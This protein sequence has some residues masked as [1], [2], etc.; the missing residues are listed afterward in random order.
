M[1]IE[2]RLQRDFTPFIDPATDLR[3]GTGTHGARLQFIRNGVEHDYFYEFATRSATARHAKGRK[4]SNIRS[5]LASPEFADIRGLAA[6][7]ARTHRNTDLGALIP[8]E[9][10]IN[11]ERLTKTS[12]TRYLSP[13]R[14]ESDEFPDKIDLVLIDGPAGVGKTSLIESAM[15]QRARKQTDAGALPPILHVASRGRRLT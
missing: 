10:E 2:A 6:T 3:I 8:P 12:L 13:Q 5:L 4:F 9:G 7:Q 11:T 14:Y 15:V 1:E